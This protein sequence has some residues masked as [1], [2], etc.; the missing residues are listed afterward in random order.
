VPI[1]PVLITLYGVVTLL[2]LW[3]R[4]RWPGELLTHLRLQLIAA[5]LI[6]A[7][8]TLA[9]G[10]HWEWASIL[11]GLALVHYGAL[12]AQRWVRPDAALA[13][14]PGLTVVWANVWQKRNA[15]ERTL[16][17]ASAQ[18]AD[19]IITGE[20]PEVDPAEFLTGDYPHRLDTGP[21]PATDYAVRMVVFSRAPI[22]GGLVRQG[23]GPM[24]RPFLALRAMVGGTPLTVMGVHPVP[25]Y[26]ASLLA[27]RDAHIHMLG[28]MLKAPF[29]LAGDF[30]TTPWCPGYG[31]IPGRRVGGYLWAPTW[32]SNL[33]LLGLP[34]DHIMIS[35]GMAASVYRV[36][37]STGSDHRAILA[38]VHPPSGAKI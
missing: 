3:R 37:G 14:Q 32:F 10:E 23:P 33:P 26:K 34:I 12:P 7:G 21:A 30:N 17:W 9:L 31:A 4:S 29:V 24:A 28:P 18:N 16:A 15:L 25:P 2:S 8:L 5:G 38:R 27:E 11:A 13:G 35:T 6:G 22:E 20:F 1:L 19:V 36:A